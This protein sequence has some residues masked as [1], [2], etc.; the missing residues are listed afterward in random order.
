MLIFTNLLPFFV[1]LKLFQAKETESD[2][3]LSAENGAVI[4]PDVVVPK[5]PAWSS[6]KDLQA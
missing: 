3:L 4:V 5:A 6:N 2:P 1:R